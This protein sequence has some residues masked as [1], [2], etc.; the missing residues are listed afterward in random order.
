L[1]NLI[2]TILVEELNGNVSIGSE[3]N[4]STSAY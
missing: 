4:A 3:N 2:H 1:A